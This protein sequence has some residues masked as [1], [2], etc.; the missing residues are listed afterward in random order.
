[1]IVKFVEKAKEAYWILLRDV[2]LPDLSHK[3]F[4]ISIPKK[5][6]LS[7]IEWQNIQDHVRQVTDIKLVSGRR[8]RWH[9]RNAR[10]REPESG[11]N[12]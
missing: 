10:N 12:S 7:A 4:T 8:A 5:N 2:S 6:R 11:L 3:S 1:M 9:E